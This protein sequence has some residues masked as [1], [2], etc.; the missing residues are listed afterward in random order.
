MLK[1]V[2]SPWK[3]HL[4]GLTSQIWE[5]WLLWGKWRHQYVILLKPF[6]SYASWHFLSSC[7]SRLVYTSGRWQWCVSSMLTCR[8]D[9]DNIPALTKTLENSNSQI[10]PLRQWQRWEATVLHNIKQLVF[11]SCCVT[12]TRRHKN[13]SWNLRKWAC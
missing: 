4:V 10:P 3:W 7:A 1:C 6:S 5:T 13:A 9:K 8:S 11:S 2:F 12:V